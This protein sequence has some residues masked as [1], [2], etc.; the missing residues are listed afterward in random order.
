MEATFVT[1]AEEL[2][3]RGIAY[4]HL[5]DQT[6][7]GLPAIPDVLIPQIR[8]AFK[9][10]IILCGGYDAKR[11]QTAIDAGLADLIAFGTPYLANPDLPARL[12][13]GWPLNEPDRETFYGGD[14]KGY[15][16]YPVYRP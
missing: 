2:N 8:D 5:N 16:D 6:T 3:R 12:E 7:F 14:E 10:P 4:L 11:A 13:R 15:T 9:G 1:L